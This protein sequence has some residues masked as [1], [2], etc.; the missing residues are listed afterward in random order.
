M[1]LPL[2]HDT[3]V[4]KGRDRMGESLISLAAVI[5]WL[6]TGTALFV[7]YYECRCWQHETVSAKADGSVLPRLLQSRDRFGDKG[8][9]Y[10]RRGR[11]WLIVLAGLMTVAIAL[12]RLGLS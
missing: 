6:A 2:N 10:Q 1:T 5:V 9:L 4:R 8:R 11:R 3:P 12:K 7:G